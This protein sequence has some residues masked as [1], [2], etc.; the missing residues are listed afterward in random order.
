[1]LT[2]HP[3]SIQALLNLNTCDHVVVLV[4]LSS[5]TNV[6]TPADR[7]VY[8]WSRSP[9]G[10]LHHYFCS[11]HWDIP[12][13]VDAAVSYVT[14]VVMLATQK[15]V[16]SCVPKL[17]QPTPWWNRCCET[18]WQRK[19]DFWKN[20]DSAGFHQASL[21]IDSCNFKTLDRLKRSWLATAPAVWNRLPADIILRG[22]TAAGALYYKKHSVVYVIDIYVIM[23]VITVKKDMPGC[24]EEMAIKLLINSSK[25]HVLV[26]SCS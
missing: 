9:W 10:R 8:H 6:I 26:Y 16:P 21:L 12:N 13:S 2:E 14:N 11:F 4:T 20:G 15:F 7:R 5:F 19:M 23:R 18:A 17:S 22:E 1:M 3:G 25:L 24:R